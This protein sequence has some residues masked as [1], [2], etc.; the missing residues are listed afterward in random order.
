MAAVRSLRRNRRHRIAI[1]RMPGRRCDRAVAFDR[2]QADFGE[3]EF[4]FEQQL[5][6]AYERA[7]L[8]VIANLF[9]GRNLRTFRSLSE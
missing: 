8:L 3:S 6:V 5:S 1:L 7:R 9:T 2:S 4:P